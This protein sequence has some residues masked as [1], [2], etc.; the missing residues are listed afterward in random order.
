MPSTSKGTALERQMND[1]NIEET[2]ETA[3]KSNGRSSFKKEPQIHSRLMDSSLIESTGT[4]A[5][6]T[7]SIR[8]TL[9]IREPKKDAIKPL[10]RGYLFIY[11][12]DLKLAHEVSEIL[13]D[14]RKKARDKFHQRKTSNKTLVDDNVE[15]EETL[16]GE[17]DYLF[18]DRTAS[19]KSAS[20]VAAKGRTVK[21]R[22]PRGRR[23][24]NPMTAQSLEKMEKKIKERMLLLE[25]VLIANRYGFWNYVVTDETEFV[26]VTLGK[27]ANIA[28][29]TTVSDSRKKTEE[30]YRYEEE[31]TMKALLDEEEGESDE[32]E[33]DDS[34][35][36]YT[37][38]GT[39]DDVDHQPVTS[40][41]NV[42]EEE[43]EDDDD[44]EDDDQLD[45]F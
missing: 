12:N 28:I 43:E 15:G 37:L 13:D 3:D 40:L 31:Y 1:L 21:S 39:Q 6:N 18:R 11:T 4:S 32:D 25:D 20:S 16:M 24:G 23:V 41:V 38:I 36:D 33:E 19:Q 10:F 45:S 22:D 17:E 27:E 26:R 35:R 2:K 7:L 9:T 5:K 42:E 34:E 44:N 29:Q 14:I 8:F 30:D